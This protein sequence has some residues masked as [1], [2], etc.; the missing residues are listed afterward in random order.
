MSSSTTAAAA[1]AAEP[2]IASVTATTDA[3]SFLTNFGVESV[4]TKALILLFLFFFSIRVGFVVVRRIRE[5]RA[6]RINRHLLNHDTRHHHEPPAE[7][8]VNASTDAVVIDFDAAIS[9]YPSFVYGVA[10]GAEGEGACSS[11]G[12]GACVNDTTCPICINEYEESEVMRIMPH[13]GH[14]FHLNCIDEWLKINW[15]CPVCRHSPL[16]QDQ[17][18]SC[19]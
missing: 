16:Q 11:A 6:D 8:N 19:S 15:S 1:A 10:A 17:T 14:Y 5:N 13:C 18:P 3:A 4:F 2:P 7:S 12:G 9:A